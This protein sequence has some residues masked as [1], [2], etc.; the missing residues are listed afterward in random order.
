MFLGDSA[1]EIVSAARSARVT[2]SILNSALSLPKREDRPPIST[3][4]SIT[5]GEKFFHIVV[6]KISRGFLSSLKRNH[7]TFRSG[8]F[9]LIGVAVDRDERIGF[10]KVG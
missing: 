10:G 1:A 8:A 7:R 4:A 9:A 2:P 6:L 3:K 5:I